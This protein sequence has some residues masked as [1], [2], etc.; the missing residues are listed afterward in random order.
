MAHTYNPS[1]SGGKDR[2]A[3]QVWPYLKTTSQVLLY[4][5]MIPATKEV[6]VREFRS[7]AK[8]HKNQP[9]K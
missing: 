3:V 6:F 5:M 1:H 4:T 7:K 2:I 8:M 9:E